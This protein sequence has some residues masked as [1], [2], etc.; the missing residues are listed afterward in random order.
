MTTEAIS[1]WCQWSDRLW[2]AMTERYGY[3]GLA[4][5][6]QLVIRSKREKRCA[7]CGEK[8]TVRQDSILIKSV[9]HYWFCDECNHFWTNKDAP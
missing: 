6:E 4:Y 2:D 1:E 7:S 5:T 9:D 3:P 8:G